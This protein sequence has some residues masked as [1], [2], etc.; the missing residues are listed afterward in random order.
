MQVMPKL[1]TVVLHHQ[2]AV[3]AH[4]DWLLSDP[5]LAGS[6]APEHCL[7]AARTEYPSGD[8]PMLGSFCLEPLPRHRRRYLTYQGPLGQ[9]RGEVKRV[10]QGWFIPRLWTGRRIVLDLH[11]ESGNSQVELQMLGSNL[12]QARVTRP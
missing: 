4:Y 9:G 8:W 2:T 7:W 10:D 1:P 6:D 3:G 12:W 5:D 11:L